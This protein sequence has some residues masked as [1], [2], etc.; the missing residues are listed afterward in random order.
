MVYRPRVIDAAVE[1]SLGAVG[2]VLI[3][4]VRAC[5]K[6]ET[7][8]HHSR[9][10]VRFDTDDVARELAELA[11]ERVLR[12]AVPRLLDEWQLVPKIWNHVRR[13]VDDRKAPGQFI[14]TGSARP[15]DDVTRHSGAGRI[16]RLRMRPMSLL[17]SGRSTGG[18]SLKALVDGGIADG[19]SLLEIS[20]LADVLCLGGWPGLQRMTPD[21]AQDVLRSY[22]DDVAR[23]DMPALDGRQRDF[24]RIRRVL[25]AY[26][27]HVATPAAIRTITADAM[28]GSS[29]GGVGSS[30][31][32]KRLPHGSRTRHGGGGTE[33]LGPPPPIARCRAQGEHQAFRRP[34]IGGRRN[35]WE[36]G[37]APGRSPRVRFALRVAGDPRSARVYTTVR[38]R[39][40]PLS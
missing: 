31:H 5:G 34:V 28:G 27:R 26:A 39:S 14:L 25:A 21:A 22:L 40:A 20:D 23:V 24:A 33:I 18:V 36:P 9:S 15:A 17:E 11:P 10:V 1:R 4:G 19:V 13:V 30:D 38:W 29:R 7:G 16:L 2:A 8:A 3:E 6:T 12:G 37:S 32:N 35:G